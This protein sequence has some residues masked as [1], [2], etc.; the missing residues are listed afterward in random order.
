M[1]IESIKQQLKSLKLS[2]AAREL[3]TVLRSQRSTVHY[4]WLGEL[5][6]TEIDARRESSLKRRLSDARF[7]ELCAIEQFDFAFNRSIDESRL[8]HLAE[9]DFIKHRQIV[10]FLGQPG[11]GKTHLAT[12]IGVKAVHQG[13]KVYSTSTRQLAAD[14]IAAQNSR[15]IETLSRRILSAQLWIL[16]DWALTPLPIEVAEQLFE[17][18]DRRK[19]CG[20]L[21]LTSN[22]DVTEWPALFPEPILA[23]ATIDR[24]FDRAEVLT[25]TGKSYRLSGRAANNENSRN[26]P[27]QP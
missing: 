22:R 16:D 10:L 17:L 24:L 20:A 27:V 23:S 21:L 2:T 3:D 5:L 6:Q 13:L 9:L 19:Y 25:F 15:S 8:R 1:N 26:T 7:P 11:T 18:L 4:Q 14:I 12:A